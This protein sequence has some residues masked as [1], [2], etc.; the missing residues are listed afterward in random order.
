[1]VAERVSSV[2]SANRTEMVIVRPTIR[3]F[4]IRRAVR[5]AIRSSSRRTV[6]G[7]SVSWP[8]V[9][10][11]PTLCSGSS[12]V[13]RR[14][15][16]PHASSLS[17]PLACGPKTGR[18]AASWGVGEVADGEDAKSMQLLCSRVSHSPHRLHWQRVQERR[19]PSGGTSISPSGFAALRGDL[20]DELGRADTD[21]TG[22]LLFVGHDGAHVL[23]DLR[24]TAEHPHGAGQVQECLVDRRRLDDGS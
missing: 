19:D 7:S 4:R 14:R 21:R 3:C 13:T 1:M 8:N 23:S 6:S 2:K 20:G 11:E 18:K 12:G 16:L 9:S 15:S 10:C 22:D 5:S 17:M 24:R